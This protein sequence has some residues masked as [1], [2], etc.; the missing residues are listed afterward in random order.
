MFRN[1]FI[2]ST[3]AILIAFSS[4]NGHTQNQ[5]V[6]WETT[7]SQHDST[8]IFSAK[9]EAHWHIYATVLPSDEGPLPTEFTFDSLDGIELKD[10]IIEPQA[11]EEY[12]PNFELNVRYYETSVDFKQKISLSEDSKHKTHK[13]SGYITYMACNDEGCLPPVDVPFGITIQDKP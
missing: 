10:G 6:Q 1:I 4:N 12:D 9:I 13:I 7:Y 11:I 8:M 3:I 5:P 2:K